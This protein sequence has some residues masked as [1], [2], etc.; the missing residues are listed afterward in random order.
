[1]I[2]GEVEELSFKYEIKD[3]AL[4]DYELFE[5]LCDID[6]GNTSLYPKAFKLLLGESQYET[7]KNAL[8]KKNGRISTKGMMSVFSEIMA[9]TKE[10][11]K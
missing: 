3:E 8:K 11:K 1:M 4:D 2:I 6:G 5:V 7:L 9:Q 10:T